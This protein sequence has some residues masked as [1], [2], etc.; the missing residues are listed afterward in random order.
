[1]RVH[2]CDVC[3][4]SRVV[5]VGSESLYVKMVVEFLTATWFQSYLSYTVV[6]GGIR[7]PPTPEL[8]V[9]EQHR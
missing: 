1:M 4:S 5:I 6:D 7:F 2:D 9:A 8:K 3:S